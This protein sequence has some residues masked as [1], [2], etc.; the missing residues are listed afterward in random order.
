MLTSC[1]CNRLIEGDVTMILAMKICLFY[2]SGTVTIQYFFFTE[3][4]FFSIKNSGCNSL[5][6]ILVR[7]FLLT[8]QSESSL[9]QDT[10]NNSLHS[11]GDGPAVLTVNNKQIKPHYLPSVPLSA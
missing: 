1:I 11:P 7:H 10:G 2:N 6:V 8:A 3:K 4:F 5:K 9:T